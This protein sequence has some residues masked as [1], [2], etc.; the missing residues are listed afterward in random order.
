MKR[1]FMNHSFSMDERTTKNRRKLFAWFTLTC[2]AVTLTS[3][4]ILTYHLFSNLYLMSTANRYGIAYPMMPTLA[5]IGAL[6][7][8]TPIYL[9][10]W[11]LKKFWGKISVISCL[12]KKRSPKNEDH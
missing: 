5:I 7:I 3:L 9:V 10:S 1:Y 2:W 12:V 6:I 4:P 11:D 8:L